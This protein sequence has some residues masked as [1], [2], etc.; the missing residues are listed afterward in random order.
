MLYFLC[1]NELCV[2]IFRSFLA[3]PNSLISGEFSIPVDLNKVRYSRSV[4]DN[5]YEDC[6]PNIIYGICLGHQWDL[7]NL[8]GIQSESY[9][10]VE[11]RSTTPGKWLCSRRKDRGNTHASSV[12]IGHT[13]C[14][15]TARPYTF[16]SSP[17]HWSASVQNK[18]KVF[19][20]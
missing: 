4:R 3:V 15:H 20:P 5:N 9:F 12:I 2:Q 1:F 18:Y 17:D 14:D 19:V 10:G 11:F 16:P 8:A 13:Y 6:S 7:W